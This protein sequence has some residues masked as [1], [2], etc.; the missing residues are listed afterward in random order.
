MQ[1]GEPGHSVMELI[2]EDNE[3]NVLDTGRTSSEFGIVSLAEAC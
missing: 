1:K 2:V 3:G